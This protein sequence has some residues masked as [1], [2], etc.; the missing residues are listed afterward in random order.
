METVL[1]EDEGPHWCVAWDEGGVTIETTQLHVVINNHT[2]VISGSIPFHSNL[3]LR[4]LIL[5]IT[6]VLHVICL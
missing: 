5:L 4:T 1:A 2:A 6:G 3:I